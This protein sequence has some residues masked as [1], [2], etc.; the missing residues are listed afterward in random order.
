MELYFVTTNA[1]K[2]GEYNR[3]LESM[4]IKL[5]IKQIVPEKEIPE[6][7]VQNIEEVARD[8]AEKASRMFPGKTLMVEDTAFY[9]K[10]LNDYPGCL[11]DRETKKHH[12]Y[13]YWCR[14]LNEKGI[15]GKDRATKAETAIALVHNKNIEIFKGTID[16]FL[17]EKAKTGGFGWDGIFIPK[18][19]KKTFSE[20]GTKIKDKISMRKRAFKK[21]IKYLNQN[22][23]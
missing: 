2:A 5:K 21:L 12:G 15:K 18:G 11:I 22:I 19:T 10:A 17:A 9:I 1:K 4:N 6:L 23:F 7:K 20:L 8:K 13:D 3:I 16:G 14:L